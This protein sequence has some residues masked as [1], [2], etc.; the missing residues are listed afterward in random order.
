MSR[1]DN[2][3]DKIHVTQHVNSERTI[4]MV[5]EFK[6]NNH[7]P[8]HSK[9]QATCLRRMIDLYLI[10]VV[11]T[12]CMSSSSKD[13]KETTKV[14]V[15]TEESQIPNFLCRYAPMQSNVVD[16][17]PG[18]TEVHPSI[19]APSFSDMIMLPRKEDIPQYYSGNEPSPRKRQAD[20]VEFA[21]RL[22]LAR[23]EWHVVHD[24]RGR[25]VA[26]SVVRCANLS[27]LDGALHHDVANKCISWRTSHD[28]WSLA[29][30][31]VKN[32]KEI[33][34]LWLKC[35]S[36][37]WRRADIIEERSWG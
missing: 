21:R 29:E 23:G 37:A 16:P 11:H 5:Y 24:N 13:L 28:R 27:W 25:S 35:W 12:K 18:T 19:Q 8:H 2:C 31:T 17:P 7:W 1:H 30:L 10:A 15:H 33:I 6:E 36:D 26:A 20:D 9:R 3:E 4:S 32:S 34:M 14:V 22:P